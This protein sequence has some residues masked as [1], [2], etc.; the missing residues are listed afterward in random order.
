MDIVRGAGQHNAQ[1]RSHLLHS[2]SDDERPRGQTGYEHLVVAVS[3]H[4]NWLEF[5]DSDRFVASA[6]SRPQRRLPFGLG[7]RCGRD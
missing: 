5:N 6:A 1:P 7:D 3:V 2:R 4:C